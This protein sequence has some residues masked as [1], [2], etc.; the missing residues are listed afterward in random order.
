VFTGIRVR[1]AGLAVV[2]SLW[3]ALGSRAPFATAS[4]A[5]QPI[6][7]LTLA[8]QIVEASG[9]AVDPTLD[10]YYT[11]Q[12]AGSPAAVYVVGANGQTRSVVTVGVPNVDWEDLAVGR[13]GGRDVMFLSDT[14]DDA[15]RRTSTAA[16]RE[17]AVIRM[18]LPDGAIS[19]PTQ[20]AR[21]VVRYRFEYADLGARNAEAL[22]VLPGTEQFFVI[23]KARKPQTTAGVF[24]GPRDPSPTS[25]N[26]FT[27][28]GEV[29]LI[30]VSGGAVSPSGDRIALR[31]ATHAY[32]YRVHNGDVAAALSSPPVRLLLPNER[33]GEAMTFDRTGRSLLVTGEGKNEPVWQVPLPRTA[34]PETHPVSPPAGSDAGAEMD[35]ARG[36][37]AWL[38]AALGAL[39]AVSLWA[40]LVPRR[41]HVP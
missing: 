33:Q 17:F 20:R 24:A 23:E 41:R 28:V 30:G 38:L 32:V 11:E 16:R 5:P 9:L 37:P 14:G 1:R 22:I 40:A 12:D 7:V 34:G 10:V 2:V 29:N 27:K 3:L 19:E 18:D 13:V 8:G 6:E 25:V 15:Q 35:H 4:V 39:S 26:R 36:L 31:D 21:G